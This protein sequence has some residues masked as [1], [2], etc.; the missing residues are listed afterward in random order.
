MRGKIFAAILILLVVSTFV[1]YAFAQ[2]Q[3]D[4]K[5]DT[6][7]ATGGG[8]AYEFAIGKGMVLLKARIGGDGTVDYVEDPLH[9]A[10]IPAGKLHI[11]M[12]DASVQEIDLKKV[13]TVTI[14]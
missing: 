13:K 11:E 14:E 12:L 2:S 1:F 4:K 8:C 5:Q 6:V 3:P 10:I 9:H 7:K